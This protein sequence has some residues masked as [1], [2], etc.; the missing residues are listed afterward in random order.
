MQ[1]LAAI[2]WR[3]WGRFG[4]PSVANDFPQNPGKSRA[5][6]RRMEGPFQSLIAAD[7]APFG[8][9]LQPSP[10]GPRFRPKS[11]QTLAAISWRKWGHFGGPSAAWGFPQN[12]RKSRA[13]YPLPGG[14][15]LNPN[16]GKV[17]PHF[18]H[19]LQSHRKA[20]PVESPIVSS[21]S[22]SRRRWAHFGGPSVVQDFLQN[23]GKWRVS[24]RRLEGVHLIP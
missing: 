16:R 22:I 23:P 2:S 7:Y 9:R 20:R 5:L 18:G 13:P 19:R 21:P 8:H 11:D 4:W 6:Y 14:P 12:P 10:R 15:F 24:S 1:S 17:S 3:K